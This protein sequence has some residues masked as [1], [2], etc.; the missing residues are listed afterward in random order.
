[1]P[2]PTTLTLKFVYPAAK[3]HQDTRTVTIYKYDPETEE[4]SEFYRFEHP[5]TGMAIGMTTFSKK[6]PDTGEWDRVGH[7]EWTSPLSGA[8][9]LDENEM[10]IKEYRKVINKTSTSRRFKYK[11]VEYKWKASDHIKNNLYC[12]D[13]HDFVWGKWYNDKNI[14]R[15]TSNSE[16]LLERLLVTA[17]LNIWFFQKEAW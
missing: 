13:T 5:S 1:M 15:V 3:Y 7:I 2:N 4:T 14:L 8:V 9:T 12:V 17:L 16:G 11:G 6:N 10:T